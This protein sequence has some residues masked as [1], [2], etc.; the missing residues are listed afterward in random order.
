MPSPIDVERLE[1]LARP[2]RSQA[3]FWPLFGGAVAC[4]FATAIIFQTLLPRFTPLHLLLGVAAFVFVLGCGKLVQMRGVACPSCRLRLAERTAALA[5]YRRACPGCQY[6]FANRSSAPHALT[7]SQAAS[8]A[9]QTRS[10]AEFPAK[11]AAVET[12][13]YAPPQSE[14]PPDPEDISTLS[15]WLF[16]HFGRPYFRPIFPRTPDGAAAQADW[17][18]GL[19]EG[20]GRRLLVTLPPYL[21]FILVLLSGMPLATWLG[22]SAFFGWVT[23]T[24]YTRLPRTGLL[25][26]WFSGSLPPLE[27]TLDAD[28]GRRIVRILLPNPNT[29]GSR[30]QF[31]ARAPAPTALV[32]EVSSLSSRRV[33]EWRFDIESAA[34]WQRFRVDLL[35]EIQKLPAGLCPDEVRW[36]VPADASVE[37]DEIA[38]LWS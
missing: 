7:D 18:A 3:W 25:G 35:K 13:P 2:L 26:R 1:Q 16:F 17:N 30:L 9:N 34:E 38:F 31:R 11:S 22:V 23:F 28:S 14:L 12:N 29:T 27:A 24:I 19:R 5:A 10:P 6:R 21:V 4:A 32:L 15:R 33:L 37:I 20:F 36:I 8:V